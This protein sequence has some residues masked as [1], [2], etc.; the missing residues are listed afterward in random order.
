MEGGVE[1]VEKDGGNGVGKRNDVQRGG[2]YSAIVREQELGD[3]KGNDE[4]VG[5]V[6]S[7]DNEKAHGEDVPS[8]WGVRLGIPPRR[9]GYRGTGDLDNV[10]ICTEAAGK[11]C[12][13]YRDTH[14]I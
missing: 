2:S 13:L 7:S 14:N 12:R 4:G 6:L 5:G 9:R 8:C 11:N 3:H 1:G 10:I